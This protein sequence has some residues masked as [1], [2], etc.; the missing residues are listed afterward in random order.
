[1]SWDLATAKE[2]LGIADASQDAA[3]TSALAVALAVAETYCDRKFLLEDE[4]EE[5]LRA[6]GPALTLRRYP[7][8]SLTALQQLAPLPVPPPDVL[9]IP[10]N[11][12][13]DAGRGIVY[14][15]YSG[16]PYGVSG[17]WY[18]GPYAGCTNGFQLSYVGGY[19]PDELPADLEA[20]LWMAFDSLWQTTPGWGL[21]AGSPTG[22]PVQ[23]FGIDGMTI[24]YGSGQAAAPGAPVA[25]GALPLTAVAILGSYR[26]ESAALGG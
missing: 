20:A 17:I 22:G 10:T 12:K 21:P 14:T 25:W 9:P 23:A 3:V 11:W 24:N 2:R 7:L 6:N 1:M 13:V 8:V 4:T 5:F 26:A 16:G 15:G 18:A 19:D